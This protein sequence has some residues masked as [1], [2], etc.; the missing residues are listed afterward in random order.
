MSIR[1]LTFVV[2]AGDAGMAG[3]YSETERCHAHVS[4]SVVGGQQMIE[5]DRLAHNRL[6]STPEIEFSP[7]TTKFIATHSSNIS[8][9]QSLLCL[10]GSALCPMRGHDARAQSVRRRRLVGGCDFNGQEIQDGEFEFLPPRPELTAFVAQVLKVANLPFVVSVYETADPAIYAAR[11][12]M[13]EGERVVLVRQQLLNR[14]GLHQR[15]Q[16]L[17][18]IAHEMGHHVLDHPVSDPDRMTKWWEAAADRW[19]G[20][21]VALI[22]G[23]ES[24]LALQ[25]FAMTSTTGN[26]RYPPAKVR[27]AC[28]TM[29]VFDEHRDLQALVRNVYGHVSALL[30]NAPSPQGGKNWSLF[31]DTSRSELGKYDRVLQAFFVAAQPDCTAYGKAFLE[32]GL[33]LGRRGG[34]ARALYRLFRIDV[35]DAR[36]ALAASGGAPLAINNISLV[37]GEYSDLDVLRLQRVEFKAAAAC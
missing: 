22:L 14:L 32:V 10:A 34:P 7:M 5:F 11:A 28:F 18:L 20:S 33:G 23:D 25:V 2:D 16:I 37:P 15:S 31:S 6:S 9:R 17:A 8:R 35:G 26:G 1:C 4:A 21:A 36:N 27:H 3:D 24:D 19:A 30:A 13:S 29:G 12:G